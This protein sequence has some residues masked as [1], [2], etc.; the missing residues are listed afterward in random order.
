MKPAPAVAAVA[1][2]ALA[3]ATLTP[4][5]AAT[6]AAGACTDG[7]RHAWQAESVWGEEYTDAAG[8]R[9]IA[10][11]V[12]RFRTLASDAN[13][14]DYTVRT[15]D[16][17]G[18]L[19][20]TLAEDDRALAVGSW[21]TRNPVNPPTTPGRSKVVINLGDGN[22][23]FGNCT[24]T[25]TQ[26]AV[27]TVTVDQITATSAR[28]N[29]TEVAGSTGYLVG[30]NGTDDTGGGPWSITDPATARSR[31][32][33][34]L[35]PGTTYTFTVTPK[36]SDIART[37]VV[38]TLGAS[39]PSPS[40][41][42]S[43]TPTP[44][45]TVTTPPPATGRT[46]PMVGK[47]GLPWN[48]IVFGHGTNPGAFETWR[49]RPVDGVLM[50]SGRQTWNDLGWTPARRPGDLLVWS[51]P[52]FPEGIGGSNARVAAGQYDAE[53]RALAAKYVAAGWNT[54]RTIIRLGWENNGNWYQ[55]SQDKGG[56]AAWRDAYRRF[57]QQ[58]R[59]GGLTEVR[60][61]WCLNK[62]P[63]PYNAGYSWTDA[64]PGDD[65]VDVIGID[66]YDHY[67]PSTTDAAW[68]AETDIGSNPGLEDVA[69]F[70]R[71]RGKLMSIDEW[72]VVHSSTGG[73]DNP[74]YVRKMFEWTKANAE[75]LAWENTYDDDGAPASFNHKLSDGGNPR[76]AAQYRQPYPNGWSR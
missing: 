43:P 69:Q 32:F 55:W 70:V 76:A 75:I 51:I 35:L 68:N 25:F 66:S 42:P 26:P 48:S 29:W 11:D 6:T 73:G 5:Q 36:P 15:Y 23:G 10:N 27:T 4:V 34:R 53:I 24:I 63:Q 49:N 33:D 1:A 28:V 38:T 46:V 50:F 31:V 64:Y 14:V 71:A 9:R 8:V 57:V 65:V 41:T 67:S 45:P 16:G 72:G 13:T 12:T 62:E 56:V 18:A 58:A 22:D 47:S 17:N 44:T 2:L 61:N 37:V 60:W 59:L 20:Q 3:A 40:P 39:T 7:G 74:F 30:R 54:D 21:L 19:L 52:P